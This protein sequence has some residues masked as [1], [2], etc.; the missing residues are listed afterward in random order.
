[1]VSAVLVTYGNTRVSDLFRE[2]DEEVRGERLQQLWRAYGTYVIAL[3]VVFLLAVGGYLAWGDYR[4]NQAEA[5]SAKFAAA[6]ALVQP[7]NAAT[8]LEAATALQAMAAESNTV[9]RAL[10]RLQAAG[11]LLAAGERAKAVEIYDQIAKDSGEDH[12]WR[13]L[14]DLMAAYVLI[15]SAS[16]DTVIERL[17]PLAGENGVWRY[18]AKELMA[19]AKMKTGDKNAEAEF[20]ALAE[21]PMAPP[22]VRARAGQMAAVLAAG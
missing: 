16:P 13:E 8:A 10:A 17:R 18:S 9:Y 15:D 1:M 3:S 6:A 11:L 2:V 20:R 21:D 19:L 7:G 4:R 5:E 12:V 22:G 14:A